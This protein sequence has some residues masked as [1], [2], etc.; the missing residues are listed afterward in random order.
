MDRTIRRGRHAATDLPLWVPPAHYREVGAAATRMQR[1]H[2]FAAGQAE[3]RFGD[4]CEPPTSGRRAQQGLLAAIQAALRPPGAPPKAHVAGL[5]MVGVLT[6]RHLGH[7]ATATPMSA[8]GAGGCAILSH[9]NVSIPR[10]FAVFRIRMGRVCLAYWPFA[11][12]RARDAASS[13]DHGQGVVD[14]IKAMSTPGP[15]EACARA[16]VRGTSGDIY[17]LVNECT[18]PHMVRARARLAGA[19]EPGHLNPAARMVTRICEEIARARSEEGE[20]PHLVN[21]LVA[22]VQAALAAVNWASTDGGHVLYRLLCVTPFTAFLAP[23]GELALT[24]SLGRLFDTTV[25]SPRWLRRLAVVWGR[26]ATRRILDL[27][28]AWRSAIAAPEA[29]APPPHG[30]QDL[31]LPAE[32][33]A[34]D[35]PDHLVDPD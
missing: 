7:N 32:G 35:V 18:N 6:C 8:I 9:C 28:G 4:S 34:P 30:W 21:P 20:P 11:L 24:H 2:A 15:C 10:L 17:H 23:K 19:A 27:A 1:Q 3:A 33:E 14:R 12:P 25:A 29:A 16:G 13:G 5:Y 22:A 31:A 26:W